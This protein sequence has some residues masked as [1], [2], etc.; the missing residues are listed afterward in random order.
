[1]IAGWWYYGSLFGAGRFG[2]VG[3]GAARSLKFG[4]CFHICVGFGY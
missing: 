2:L 1:M 3:S 4:F